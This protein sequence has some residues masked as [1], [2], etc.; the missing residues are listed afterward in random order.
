MQYPL[1]MLAALSVMRVGWPASLPANL[2]RK[3][4]GCPEI[5]LVGTPACNG[6]GRHRTN[7][8][9]KSSCGNDVSIRILIHVNVFD[10][11]HYKCCDIC[12]II[13]IQCNLNPLLLLFNLIKHP[14]KTGATLDDR[15]SSIS[16]NMHLCNRIQY[17]DEIITD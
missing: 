11:C 8:G 7:N 1:K 14:F 2:M 17:N 15:R 10:C 3:R 4:S 6:S 5:A 12:S 16:L 9:R 13:Y